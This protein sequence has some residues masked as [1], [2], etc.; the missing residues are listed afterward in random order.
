MSTSEPPPLRLFLD[1]STQGKRF[2]AAVRE[3]VDDV[4]TINDRYGVKPAESIPD[5]QM[6]P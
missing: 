1:R 6:D 4:E 2:V 5:I 3:L